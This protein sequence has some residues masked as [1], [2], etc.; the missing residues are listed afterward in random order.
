LN[1]HHHLTDLKQI[2]KP[3]V[4]TGS[5]DGVHQGHRVILE[6]LKRSAAALDGESVLITFHPHP[7]KVL[8]PDTHGKTLRL[9]TTQKEKERLLAQTGLDHLIVIE[10][11]PDF[12]RMPAEDFITDILVKKLGIQK[13]ITGYN[14]HFGHNRVGN[15]EQMQRFGDQYG[16]EVEEIPAQEIHQESTSSAIIRQAIQAGR[17]RK[18]NRHLG[19]QYM[20]TGDHEMVMQPHRKWPKKHLRIIPENENKL[21][22][23]DGIYAASCREGIH[24]LQGRCI[25][26]NSSGNP[27]DAEIVFQ[28]MDPIPFD[29]VTPSIFFQ[30]KIKV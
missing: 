29:L 13:V 19:Y 25:V 6:R 16:F 7:R 12:S 26:K 11:T 27:V 14:H 15:T 18:A 1:I 10:F 5:F 4:T 9:I 2:R 3:I 28:C 24:S 30:H 23:P 17:I 21:L 8:Y 20:I 22:P